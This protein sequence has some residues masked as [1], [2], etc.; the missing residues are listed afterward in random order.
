MHSF[1]SPWITETRSW[2]SGIAKPHS[3]H[4]GMSGYY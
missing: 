4:F 2:G 1:A 3:G